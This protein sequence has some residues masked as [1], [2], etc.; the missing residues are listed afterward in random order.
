MTSEEL[1]AL[2]RQFE[3][4]KGPVQT[5]E[6]VIRSAPTGGK[7]N[8]GRTKQEDAR[9]QQRGAAAGRAAQQA[10]KPGCAEY[11]RQRGRANAER[12]VHLYRQG[13]ERDVIAQRVGISSRAVNRHIAAEG[14]RA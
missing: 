2:M 5:A 4:D 8:L 12:V 3:A 14:L 9:S 10:A 1:A 7:F 13:V 11:Q 6:I